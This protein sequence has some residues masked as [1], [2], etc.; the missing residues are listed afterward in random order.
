VHGR[1]IS[2]EEVEA[3][4][5]AVEAGEVNALARELFGGAR[6]L[7]VLGPLDPQDVRM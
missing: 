2:T 1:Q 7:C 6:G 3:R 4:F 5:D